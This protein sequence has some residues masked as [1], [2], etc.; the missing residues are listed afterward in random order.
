M[1]QSQI[2][3]QRQS[4]RFDGAVSQGNESQPPILAMKKGGL[5]IQLEL[6]NQGEGSNFF[7]NYFTPK[8]A[9]I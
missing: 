7:N 4:F 6:Q 5:N 1:N 8:S 3:S 9:E 2:N